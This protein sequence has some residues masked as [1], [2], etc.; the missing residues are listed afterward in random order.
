MWKKERRKRRNFTRKYPVTY[1]DLFL[2]ALTPLRMRIRG[3]GGRTIM[4]SG[5]TLRGSAIRNGMRNET[6]QWGRICFAAS[7]VAGLSSKQEAK[8]ISCY[9]PKLARKLRIIAIYTADKPK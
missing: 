7:C 5:R 9:S 6:D 4:G 3:G 2:R 1:N 8:S